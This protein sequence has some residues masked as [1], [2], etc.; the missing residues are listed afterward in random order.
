MMGGTVEEKRERI[1]KESESFQ[2]KLTVVK[3]LLNLVLNVLITSIDNFHNHR[4]E[5]YKKLLAKSSHEELVLV[6]KL[7]DFHIFE[8]ETF[9]K[10]DLFG[11][12]IELKV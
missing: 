9:R 2:E 1:N 11:E 3:E 12:K 6:K 4:A 8:L 7:M 5:T 10:K